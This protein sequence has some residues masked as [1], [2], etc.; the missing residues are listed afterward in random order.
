MNKVSIIIPTYNIADYLGE[1]LS[2]VFNQSYQNFEVIVIDGGSIDG[3]RDIIKNY[4]Q[5]YGSKIKLLTQKKESGV[6]GAR[7]LGIE[8]STGEIVCFLDGDDFLLENSI[9]LRVGEFDSKKSVKIAFSDAF[10]ARDNKKT[11]KKYLTKRTVDFSGG[12]FSALVMD[13]PVITSSVMIKK[14]VLDKVGLFST[15]KENKSEDLDLWVRIAKKD[16]G[17]KFIEQP[18]LFYRYRKG[19]L[20][21]SKIPMIEGRLHIFDKLLAENLSADKVTIIKKAQNK[22]LKELET[23][24]LLLQVKENIRNGNY[25]EARNKFR[26]ILN[27]NPRAKNYAIMTALK[28]APGLLRKVYLKKNEK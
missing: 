19:S 8:K 9:L 22:Y 24:K 20:S 27:R 10:V 23:E 4:Q 5:K 15:E 28:I 17:Y 25:K 2:S 18:T 21:E 3:T 26:K 7:N 11:R 13:N 12:L 1:C 6:A 14:D 16:Y